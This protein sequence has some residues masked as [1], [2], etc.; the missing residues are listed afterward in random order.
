M[1]HTE[2]HHAEP[3]GLELVLSRNAGR[4]Y[5][6]HIHAAHWTVGLVLAGTAVL[7]M[8]DAPPRSLAAGSR[9]VVRPCQAHCLAVAPRSELAVLCLEASRI[10][11][12]FAGSLTA[13]I[14]AAQAALQ[15]LYP[16]TA[17]LA[18]HVL[19]RP[20]MPGQPPALLPVH[21]SGDADAS[22]V[23]AVARRIMEAPEVPFPV[24]A[25]AEQ[26]GYSQWHFLRCFLKETGLTPHA[27]QLVC[28]LSR[29]RFLLRKNTAAAEAAVS[30]G[31][32]DQSHLHKVFKSHHG[33]TPGQ[34]L[35]ASFSMSARL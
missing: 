20:P 30:A 28:R 21:A 4:L 1:A 11:R 16:S 26:A 8:R 7:G 15:P 2:Y 19:A 3:A 5:P 34:F 29:A 17:A 31:F 9:F 32:A 33:L 27:L 23:Q 6:W 24:A 14:S 13:A 18:A 25:M 12:D 10:P 22:P 35:R